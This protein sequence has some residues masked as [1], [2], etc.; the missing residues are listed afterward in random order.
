MC[1]R[2]DHK[3]FTDHPSHNCDCWL[4]IAVRQFRYEPRIRCRGEL[5]SRRAY[6]GLIPNTEVCL[7]RPASGYRPSFFSEICGCDLILLQ[8]SLG[9]YSPSTTD[10][11][12]LRPLDP[13]DS[14]MSYEPI[15]CS[16]LISLCGGKSSETVD[17]LTPI[18]SQ[19]LRCWRSYFPFRRGRIF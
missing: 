12:S 19:L 14:L 11:L 15:Q 2:E 3:E 8:G 10:S 5:P 13:G 1:P 4:V 9:C 7:P 17:A 18:S 6:V 16:K